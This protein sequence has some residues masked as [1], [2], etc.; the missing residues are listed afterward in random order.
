MW[1]LFLRRRPYL[2]DLVTSMLIHGLK[3]AVVVAAFDEEDWKMTMILY[4]NS[5]GMKN[6]VNPEEAAFERD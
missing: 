6:S 1:F 2:L 3:R 4:Q 5:L